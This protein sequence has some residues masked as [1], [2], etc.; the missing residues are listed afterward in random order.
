[1]RGS[2]IVG[3]VL[4]IATIFGV[5]LVM[6]NSPNGG[7][8]IKNA[9]DSKQPPKAVFTWGHFDVETGVTPLSPKQFGNV[10]SVT[11]ENTDVKQ[12]DVLLQVDDALAQLTVDLAKAE[13]TAGERLLDEARLLT[14]H[15]K[16]QREQQQ[17]AL[18]SIDSE[19]KELAL[20]KKSKLDSLGDIPS[21]KKTLEARYAEG[22]TK[23]EEK[24]KAEHAKLKQ[25]ELQDA[26]LKI[27]LAGADLDAKKTR[28]KQAV[29]MVKHYQIVAPSAGTVLRVHVRKGE[30]LGP[31]MRS[32]TIDFLPKGKVIVR[33]EVLQEWGRYVREKQT[34][35]IED[36]THHGPQWEGN[37]KS[38]SSWY[39][40]VRTPVIEPFRY[41]DVRTL[42]CII[43]VTSGDVKKL[44]GQ[45]VRAKI[46]IDTSK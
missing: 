33:A 13:V 45:R 4:L 39:A 29:E 32:H 43:E 5:K 3:I 18:R 19:I 37:V 24:K 27:A 22:A 41:N 21:L 38:L 26:T 44:I 14:E 30:V 16:L 42:E 2:V 15:Y 12:G 28:L 40:P 11:A 31:A 10:V 23:L 6:E 35:E 25:I 1:M 17:A 9:D 34:V 36:D 46:K 20:D 8:P 7:N